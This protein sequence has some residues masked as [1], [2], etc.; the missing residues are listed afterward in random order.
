MWQ[1]WTLK[2][3]WLKIWANLQNGQNLQVK[4]LKEI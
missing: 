4:I 1:I 2:F 3:E